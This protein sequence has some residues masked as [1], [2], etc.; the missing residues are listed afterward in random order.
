[1]NLQYNKHEC[2]YYCFAGIIFIAHY[3]ARKQSHGTIIHEYMKHKFYWFVKAEIAL[4]NT[5][6]INL[7]QKDHLLQVN[8]IG[9]I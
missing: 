1:M 2:E 7:K 9:H 8:L 4:N 5:K 6:T 3:H